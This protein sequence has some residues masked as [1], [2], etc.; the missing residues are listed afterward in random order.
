M[1]YQGHV[2]HS[3]IGQI[4]RLIEKEKI[5]KSYS[6][7]K[8]SCY[9]TK[10]RR[11]YKCM[12]LIMF[13]RTYLIIAASERSVTIQRTSKK[14]RVVSEVPYHARLCVNVEYFVVVYRSFQVRRDRKQH[15]RPD[16]TGVGAELTRKQG[17]LCAP[18]CKKSC[19]C[20]CMITASEE[21]AQLRMITVCIIS[22]N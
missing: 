14:T 3:K 18:P 1:N 5:T 19:S 2:N 22:E 17:F 10:V 16:I 12:K 4:N 9:L 8:F 11:L 7:S 21:T 15:G 6:L 20:C 13:Y